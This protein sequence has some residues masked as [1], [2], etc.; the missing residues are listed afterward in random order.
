M[1]R[2]KQTRSIIVGLLLC[3]TA[4]L[5]LGCGT[6]AGDPTVR[7]SANRKNIKWDLAIKQ[8]YY[9]GQV[10]AIRKKS[11][12]L[13]ND[14]A[15]L[16]R[17]NTVMH[18]LKRRTLLPELPYEVHY[19]DHE[20]VNAVCYPGGGILFFR[21]IFDKNKGLVN[22]YSNDEIAA[23]M[24]HEMAHAT[25]RH[26]YRRQQTASIIGFFGSVASVAVGAAGGA[27]LSRLFH[28]VFDVSTGIYFPAY[29]RKFETEA[30][31][32]GLY[33]MMHA[34]YNPEKAV[35]LWERAAQKHGSKTSIYASHPANGKRAQ[36]LHE[37]LTKIR[38]E[39]LHRR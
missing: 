7:K 6:S 9:G 13:D 20:T 10:E 39:Q 30:D 3:G 14:A 32:E 36:H 37:A 31:I 33:T 18:R 17:L 11:I 1:T 24:G 21:G 4:A 29:S 22:P 16:S 28:A 35:L 19:V 27:D 23:V 26:A 5:G 34:G 12:K 2:T 38:A 15:R 8:R 25:L